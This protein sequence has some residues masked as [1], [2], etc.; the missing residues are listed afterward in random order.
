M[1]IWVE[2]S[3]ES[4]R[5]AMV[6]FSGQRVMLGGERVEV[7]ADPSGRVLLIGDRFFWSPDAQTGA[8]N[9][10]GFRVQTPIGKL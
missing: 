5:R 7:L 4:Q 8:A 9:N 3:D 10:L 6:T 1:P 2:L